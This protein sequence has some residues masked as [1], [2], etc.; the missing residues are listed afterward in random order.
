MIRAAVVILGIV[1]A[2]PLG[3][4]TKHSST[5]AARTQEP[6]VTLDVQE[7]E[8][9]DV[10][11]SMQQQ[12]GIRNLV[13]DREVA[14]QSGTLVFRDV[15]CSRAFRIVLRMHGLESSSYDNRV[16]HVGPQGRRR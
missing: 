2:V 12:C 7:A 15:P 16:L 13:L 8:L 5:R 1:V 10:L 14:G 3:A 9:R 6:S 4:A 11:R